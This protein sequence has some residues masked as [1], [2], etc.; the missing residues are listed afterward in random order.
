MFK[1]IKKFLPKSLY[2]RVFLILVIP[3]F[4]AQALSIYIFYERH[5]DNIARQLA[6]SLAGEVVTIAEY[7]ES[8]DDQ[9]AEEKY[10]SRSKNLFHFS[11]KLMQKKQLPKY[12]HGLEVTT[13]PYYNAYLSSKLGKKFTVY[14][15]GDKVISTIV[16]FSNSVL[17]V[18][19]PYKRLVNSTSYI[20]LLWM[21]G[22]TTI[23]LLIS[24]V[25]LKNQIRPIIR[26]ARMADN[27]GR[28]ID[29]PQGFKPEGAK[30]V[31][32]AYKAFYNMHQRISRFIKQRTEMLAGISHDL[33]TPLTRMKLELALQNEKSEF[34]TELEQDIAE[35][36][37][38][39]NSYIEFVRGDD[40]EETTNQ[41]IAELL[42]EI[43]ERYKTDKIE[44]LTADKP[45]LFMRVN[46]MKRALKNIIDN[47]LKYAKNLRITMVIEA[48]FVNICFDDD[49]KGIPPEKREDVFKPFFRLDQSRNTQTGGVGLG[50]SI[51]RDIINSHGGM[52]LLEDSALGGLRVTVK[53]PV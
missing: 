41:D 8:A 17:V 26:L 43:T 11:A 5:Q 48:G 28:G 25:F 38:M 18:D 50:L 40:G 49:G 6:S 22:I 42:K 35:L 47:A 16:E 12:L 14:T 2:G 30:E 27:L 33:R 1:R 23:L 3:T 51:V 36:E 29:I 13:L 4:L 46:S 39:I 24:L 21:V 7:I 45:L 44:L 37:R 15:D 10:L 52:V 32:Q 9:I 34:V 53:L 19:V 20:F 31:R